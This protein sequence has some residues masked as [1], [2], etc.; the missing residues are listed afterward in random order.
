M[1]HESILRLIS[2]PGLGSYRIRQLI[3][4]FQHPDRV[5]SASVQELI[6]VDG[7]DKITAERIQNGPDTA[8]VTDQLQSAEKLGVNL[9][10]FWDDG[11]PDY[12]KRIHDAPVL[13]FYKGNLNLISRGGVAIVGTRNAT[14][15]GRRTA[16][17]LARD[18]AQHG[19]PVISGMARGID[20][21]AHRGAIRNNGVTAAVLGSGLDVIYP[22]E[23]QELFESIA[24]TG[25]VLSEFSLHTD[26][27]NLNFPKRNR[28]ISGLSD[29]V[30]VVEAGLKS[31]ALITAYLALEQGKEVFAVPGNVY[32][33]QSKGCHHLLK[34][35]ARLVENSRDVLEAFHQWHPKSQT[36]A[37][38][39]SQPA[40]LTDIEKKYWKQLSVEPVHIDVLVKRVNTTTAEALSVLLGLELK[41]AVKQLSGMMFIRQ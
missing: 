10:H 13:L 14:H 41:G 24:E 8:Y 2:I 17:A 9:I 27:V 33:P 7:V 18:L 4:R 30:V 11:F 5:L 3:G 25:V 12:L 23:N 38:S 20:T 31:G 1:T 22:P 26:P 34:Q 6:R 19:I 16:D 29:G 21:I 39:S 36:A 32:N 37:D 15:A 40:S 28:I 35:G